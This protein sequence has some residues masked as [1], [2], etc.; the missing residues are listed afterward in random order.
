[1]PVGTPF[2][3]GQSGNPKGREPG[4]DLR[5]VVKEALAKKERLTEDDLVDIYE[6]MAKV[7]KDPSNKGA[8]AAAKLIFDR[9]CELQTQK[10]DHEGGVSLQVVTGVPT[11]EPTDGES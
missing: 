4:Y 8:V 2:Q 7:A 1:M 9:M 11:Q 6:N 3:P 5:R 10:L